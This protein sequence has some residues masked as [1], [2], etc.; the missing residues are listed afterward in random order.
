MAQSADLAHHPDW[1]R[2]SRGLVSIQFYVNL[3]DGDR[4]WV[5]L[6]QDQGQ[7]LGHMMVEGY[8]DIVSPLTVRVLLLMSKEEVDAWR[9]ERGRGAL[10]TPPR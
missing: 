9:Q 1:K 10:D 3:P 5:D 6:W 7:E 8:R 4:L 2:N